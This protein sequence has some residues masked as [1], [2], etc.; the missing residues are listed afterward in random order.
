[1]TISAPST[2]VLESANSVDFVITSTA[3]LGTGF[4]VR[5]KPSEVSD[6]D[7]LNEGPTPTNQEAVTSQNI[8]FSSSSGNYSA[9]LA[10][11][12][13]NDEIGE[14]TG[15]IEVVLLN[16][17]AVT[18]TYR[19]ANTGSQKARATILDDD[20]PELK[21]TASGTITEG[22]GNTADFTI[23]SQIP[24]PN[25]LL[26]IYYTPQSTNFI[27]TGAGIQTSSRFVFTRNHPYTASLPLAVHDDEVSESNGT[28]SVTLHEESTPATNYTVAASPHN[29]A[30]INITDDD[31]LPLLSISAPAAPTIESTGSVNFVVL[32]ATDLGSNFRVRFQPL[33]VGTGDFLD[34]T[35]TPTSQ[36]ALTSKRLN[37]TGAFNSYSA[38]LSV[39]I[40]NDIIGERTGQ[41]AVTLLEDDA[42]VKTYKIGTTGS[43]SAKAIIFDDDTPE[44]SISG[45]NAITEGDGNSAEF[46][47]I[48]YV[49]VPNNSLAVYYTPIGADFL[50]SGSGVKT[51]STLNFTNTSPYTAP[52][53]INVEDDEFSERS[54]SIRVTLN[55]ENTPG[56]SYTVID[57]AKNTASVNVVDDDSLPVLSISAPTMPVLESTG[58]VD[59]SISA[60]SFIGSD[61]R[62]R[63][64]AS[65]VNTGDFLNANATPTSQEAISSANIDFMRNEVTYDATL[66]VPVHDDEVGEHTGQ[67]MVSLI[68]DDS[69]A[70]TY[71]IATNG[72]QT[73]TATIKDDDAPELKISAG[74]DVIEGDGN[75]ANF[76]ITS[77]LLVHSLTIN[78]S[79]HT[80]NYLEFGSGTQT[81]ATLNFTGNGPYTAPLN[82]TVHDDETA[83]SDGTIGV[84]L[85]EES[86][87]GT[88]YTVA[89]SPANVAELRVFDDDSPPYISVAAEN[90]SVAENSGPAKFM[91]ST[92]GLSTATTLM[93]N[94]TPTDVGS[95]FVAN[96]SA[97]NFS[98]MFTDPDNDKTYTGELSVPLTSDNQGEP[99]GQIKLTLNTDTA[100]TTTYNLGTTTVGYIT[101]WDD[102]AP[103]LTISAATP[104]ILEADNLTADFT[105][106]TEVS[107]SQNI[108]VRYNLTESLDYIDSEGLEK[109]VSLNFN[110]PNKEDTISVPIINDENTEDSGTITVTLLA[111]NTPISYT[112][113]ASP[114]NFATVAISDDE[115][116][117][118]ISIKADNGVVAENA[119]PAMYTLTAT[120]LTAATTLMINATPSDQIYQ[121]FRITNYLADS[122]HQVAANFPVAFS[123][124]D[125]DNIYEGQ[126][127]V[128]LDDDE[129]PEISFGLHLDGILTATLNPDP[130]TPKTYQ[131][132]SNTAGTITAFDDEVPRLRLDPKTPSV[133]E[134]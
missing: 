95:N 69:A 6:G 11:P 97:R 39:P 54:A 103:E 79:L 120:G 115:S 134:G 23:T 4:R 113:T 93:I 51:F 52:L 26:T 117:P 68:S 15:L 22:D 100:Q 78:Y 58:S 108:T 87:P 18:P 66:S 28:I 67:I 80:T 65:E 48:S 122:V 74:A 27:Q 31:S 64:Q 109:E 46:S 60:N 119:G 62:V 24:I 10:V 83:E 55:E 124:P 13:D 44:L 17:D 19:I 41:I 91:L 47:I 85:V 88:S 112:V 129:N 35:A 121:N 71:K 132:G 116:L 8:D 45:G 49:P 118:I 81:L 29:T 127:S 37:F 104:T 133:V 102:D 21:I 86:T 14:H 2:P 36:E 1:M 106:S 12:I 98:V 75:T 82:L 105:V 96:S 20:A 84:T 101:V 107:N 131:L 43:Q 89:P 92:T 110:N 9:T 70:Q 130:A 90:G 33:E 61:F 50:E 125:N 30:S 63:Y 34:E 53:I 114:N 126:L 25:N 57:S 38:I 59:F 3:D 128:T 42:I 73:A 56:T 16:D 7:F 76:T 40:H 5:Y 72:S 111:D 32:A 77:E 94:A 123:D 99:T